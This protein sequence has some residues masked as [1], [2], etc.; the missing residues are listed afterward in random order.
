MMFFLVSCASFGKINKIY[1]TS[2]QK[3]IS[4]E[5]FVQ[6]VGRN[7]VHF[8]GEFHN[9]L[10]IQNAQARIIK[11]ITLHENRKNQF[12]IHWEF[13]N[14]TEKDE[15]LKSLTK[16][17][18][19]QMNATQFITK[20][21]GK[22]NLEYTS[23]IELLDLYNG[24]INPLNIPRSI[25]QKII[26]EGIESINQSLIPYHHYVGGPDYLERFRAVMGD[27]VSE[28][29]MLKYFEVQCLTDSIMANEISTNM[30]TPLNFIIAG[31]F[32]TDFHSATVERLKKLTPKKIITYKF[33]SKNTSSKKE[34]N[35]YLKGDKRY[36]AYADFII[37]TE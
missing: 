4:I 25:K 11:E 9:T 17:K 26:K 2:G 34:I 3:N 20:H 13:L 24:Y 32:H 6:K 35:A 16:L 22:Q 10:E 28:D 21:A 15:I 30:G 31:S 37:I 33:V 5:D 19:K 27:H 7:Q 14:H 29:L 1:D 36:G 12:T 23:I 8:M 18:N